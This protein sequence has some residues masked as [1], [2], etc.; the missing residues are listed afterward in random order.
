MQNKRNCHLTQK[1]LLFTINNKMMKLLT[2][3]TQNSYITTTSIY[4]YSYN[5]LMIHT[6]LSFF[7]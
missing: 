2:N 1:I 7:L 3:K 4:F 5:Y 6:Y